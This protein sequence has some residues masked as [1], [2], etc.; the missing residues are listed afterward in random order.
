MKQTGKGYDRINFSNL[1]LFLNAR[2]PLS[3]YALYLLKDCEN[4]ARNFAGEIYRC[5]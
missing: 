1:L 5:E 2:I 3:N 4:A